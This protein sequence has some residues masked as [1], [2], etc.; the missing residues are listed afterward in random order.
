[1]KLENILKIGEKNSLVRKAVNFGLAGIIAASLSTGCGKNPMGPDVLNPLPSV[2][3]DTQ[4]VDPLAINFTI[5][6]SG[7]DNYGGD[8]ISATATLAQQYPNATI[9]AAVKSPGAAYGAYETV[10]GNTKSLASTVPGDYTIKFRVT[11]TNSAGILSSAEKESAPIEVY[12]NEVQSDAA[13]QDAVNEIRGPDWNTTP[14]LINYAEFNTN[15]YTPAVVD[16]AIGFH[17]PTFMGG[18]ERLYGIDVQ[19]SKT[20]LFNTATDNFCMTTETP[21]VITYGFIPKVKTQD[22]IKTALTNW[23]SANWPVK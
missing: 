7:N 12:M 23:Q 10:T 17:D 5:T 2:T 16:G 18:N 20:D 9:E 19:G 11:G 13:L 1:M 4:S 8:I 14:Y 6:T 22:E 3:Q 15:V 21:D